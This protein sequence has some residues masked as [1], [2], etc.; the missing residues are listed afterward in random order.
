MALATLKAG[1]AVLRE[2]A[3]TL[4]LFRAPVE[5]PAGG[6]NELVGKLM[7]LLIE[8]RADSRKAKNFAA[9]DKIRKSLTEI[10][11]VLEDR[12]DGTGWSIQR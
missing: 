6:G 3:G 9:A 12:A 8:V 11:V 10:G 4:G 1:A 5:Q 7:A 2:L